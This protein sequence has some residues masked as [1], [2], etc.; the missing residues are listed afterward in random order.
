MAKNFRLVTNEL[1]E[2]TG[3]EELAAQIGCSVQSVKQARMDVASPSHRVPPPGWEAAVIKLIDVRIAQ[4][5]RL[6]IKLTQE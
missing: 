2:K 3:A 1:F 4:L 6:K 5:A